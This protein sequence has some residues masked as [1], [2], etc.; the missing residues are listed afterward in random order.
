MSLEISRDNDR[1]P[2]ERNVI[3]FNHPRLQEVF[4]EALDEP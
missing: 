4:S 1:A 3:L 2:E